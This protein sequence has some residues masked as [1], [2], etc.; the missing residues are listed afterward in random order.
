MMLDTPTRGQII[1]LRESGFDVL[2]ICERLNLTRPQEFRAVQAL[3]D[4]LPR[5]YQRG[6]ELTGPVKHGPN[7]ANRVYG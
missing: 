4:G 5:L 1:S 2:R 6:P 7:R 3:C